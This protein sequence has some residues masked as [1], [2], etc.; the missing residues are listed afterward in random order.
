MERI[1]TLIDADTIAKKIDQIANAIN[2]D[3][4]DKEPVLICTLKGAVPFCTDLGKKLNIKCSSV[5][6]IKVSSYIGEKSNGKPKVTSTK[7]DIKGKDVIVVEDIIDT[8]YT[9]DTLVN[10]YLMELE[11]NSVEVCVL[12]DKESKREDDNIKPR[13]TGFVIPDRFVI[14]YGLDKDE[15]Y[16]ILPDI[17]CVTNELDDTLDKDYQDILKQLDRPVIRVEI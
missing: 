11:P 14:G 12:L 7:L 2:N 8:G 13:Y 17:K 16:R 10:D 1:E 15:D 3:Y 6:Y 9:L 4:K 5:E